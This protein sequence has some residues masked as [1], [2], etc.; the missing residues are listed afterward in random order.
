MQESF[1]HF[2][3]RTFKWLYFKTWWECTHR[4]IKILCWDSE[5]CCVLFSV[6]CYVVC[7]KVSLEIV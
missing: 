3:L 1:S 7:T 4:R 2:L 6:A 5:S